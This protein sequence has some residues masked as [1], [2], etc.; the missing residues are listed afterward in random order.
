MEKKRTSVAGYMDKV[1]K[2]V[3]AR[4]GIKSG[5]YYN[6]E[7]FSLKNEKLNLSG[8]IFHSKYKI[9]SMEVLV[10]TKKKKVSMPVDYGFPRKDVGEMY[11]IPNGFF[12]GLQCNMLLKTSEKAKVYLHVKYKKNNKKILL[13]SIAAN[14]LNEENILSVKLL[15]F[16]MYKILRESL[17][18][19][20][21][22][23]MPEMSCDI[24]IPV[25][26]GYEYLERM[27]SDIRKTRMNTTIYLIDDCSPDE[28]V[29]PLLKAYAEKYDNVK[30]LQN[31]HNLGF[32]GTVNRALKHS[33]CDVALVNT[34]VELPEYWLERL[35]MPIFTDDTV[36]SSTPYSN[37]A[38]IFSFPNI[39]EN[40]LI[41]RGL[42]VKC[43]D[44]MFQ[45]I[46]PHYEEVPTGMGFCMGMSR[47]ALNEIGI[48][49]YET[50]RKGYGEEND[51]CRRA[52][53]AGYHNVQ[54]E[55][56]FVY[57]KHGGSFASQEKKQL[58]EKNLKILSQRYPDYLDEVADFMSRD[59]NKDLREL[60]R[61]LIDSN[62]VMDKVT[63][64]FDHN[65]G[66]GATDYINNRKR[67][68][69][70]KH[71]MFLIVRYDHMQHRNLIKIYTENYE[72]EFV[73]R[74]F[75][76][77]QELIKWIPVHSVIVNELVSYADIEQV[78]DIIKKIAR[79]KNAEL[80]MLMHDYY[81]FCP[82]VNLLNHEN[83]YCGLPQNE[84]CRKCYQDYGYFELN[85]CESIVEWQKMW[86]DFLKVCTSILAFSEDTVKKLERVYG[87]FP[88]LILKPHE[89][90]YLEPI[91]KK[92]KTTDSFNIGILGTMSVHK[93][94][95]IIE[96]MAEYLKQKKQKITITVVG[97][98]QSISKNLRDE[99]KQTGRYDVS[100]LPEII[101]KNDIDLFL[102]PSIW[103]ET[104]S[105]T[106]EEIM[107]LNM[108]VAC[109]ALGAPAE[110]VAK[111]NKG[112]VLSSMR[113]EDVI[114]K[115]HDFAAEL[116]IMQ[117]AKQRKNKR[118]MYVAE[119]HDFATRYRVEHLMEEMLELG[120]PGEFYLL[121]RVPDR[122]EWNSISSIVIYRCEYRDKLAK[123][124]E[125]AKEKNVPVYYDVDDYVFDYDGIKEL[126]FL[127]EEKN[128]FQEYTKKIHKAMEL[129]DSFITS[130]ETL[131]KVIEKEFAGQKVWL[132]RNVAS[133]QMWILSNKALEQKE[134]NHK[135]ES[136][137]IVL[138]YFS[139]SHTHSADF[140]QI[141]NS[142]WKIMADNPNVYLKVVGCLM[143][144]E[145]FK[146][147]EERVEKVDF[148][149]WQKLPQLL[150]EID[151]NLMPLENS[152]FHACKSENK[153]MEA[154]MVKVPTIAS[155]NEELKQ[156]TS[157]GEDILLCSNEKDWIQ[158]LE[159]LVYDRKERRRIAQN[160]WVK[161]SKTKRTS[162]VGELQEELERES[163]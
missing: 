49:D 10:K 140:E 101:W 117:Q 157:E 30:L 24:I 59:P 44:G 89:V 82:S 79:I 127:K 56:L 53:K 88:Q 74:K 78:L 63:I 162:I 31:K 90:K 13:G 130:T 120:V 51:W 97:E 112:L 9:N 133:E 52:I 20:Y 86:R 61:V 149:D 131:K 66:G 138:G 150:S 33:T 107:R 154:A 18:S 98:A 132:N 50:F 64:A 94:L 144:P 158:A 116:G 152:L 118:I 163:V 1:S 105:Y 129:V 17:Q 143:L 76:Q 114:C 55:N 60:M 41:Y 32:V 84:V 111:Y 87:E 106:T 99:I 14:V 72:I 36:A 147:V 23:E 45:K 81:A 104:F 6:I 39:G 4:L 67:E 75:K 29:F 135:L 160:A 43:I 161:A 159:L 96:Q 57:H 109:F 137:K 122:I 108:P 134:L 156:C 113:A 110:R 126:A 102:I 80:I 28:R 115:L 27:L 69:I 68:S 65:L 2:Y 38:T 92:Y 54:V 136:K 73:F 83:K 22:P 62:Y 21:K 7:S 124:V 26:N 34:D 142:V 58:M 12:S 145:I 5:L 16:D 121:N 42:D 103:P 48:L 25:Y 8:W 35:M 40:N 70:L 125:Q 148:V 119:R 85:G 155:K 47:R 151:I 46:C 37:S 100:E 139:G 153:W 77:I 11:E 141:S 19:E 15:E 3:R 95:H 93:G 123:L 71:E 146:K 128:D 91:Q